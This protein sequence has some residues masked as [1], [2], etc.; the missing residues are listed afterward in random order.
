MRLNKKFLKVDIQLFD[1]GN[2]F[3]DFIIDAD[4]Y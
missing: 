2:S 1:F 4:I 3:M